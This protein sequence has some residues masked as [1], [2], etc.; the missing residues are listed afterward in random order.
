MRAYDPV[1]RGIDILGAG[2]ALLAFSPLFLVVSLLILFRDGAPVIYRHTRIGR[3]RRPF[4]MWKFRTMVRDAD[5]V[6]GYQTLERDPR[7]TPVGRWLR[8]TSVDEL[9]Q[10]LN[11]LTG[12]MSLIGPRPDTPAQKDLYAPGQ[13][14][15][16]HRIRPGITGLAQVRHKAGDESI[17]R[18]ELDIAYV[19]T[20][21]F[22]LD[23]V[24]LWRTIGNTLRLK[25]S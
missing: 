22:G 7:I 24:I 4:G 12:E 16:R 13:W 18:P 17:G 11:V 10:L 14:E 21:S 25:N 20:R 8:K 1:K 9:P 19:R 5:K 3:N 6:G 2:T 15:E 23:L